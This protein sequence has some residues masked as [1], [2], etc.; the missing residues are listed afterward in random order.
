MF[1]VHTTDMK[2]LELWTRACVIVWYHGF[3]LFEIIIFEITWYF[4][5]V[6]LILLFIPIYP[7]AV[8][9]FPTTDMKNEDIRNTYVHVQYICDNTTITIFKKN[10]FFLMNMFLILI[11]TEWFP[12]WYHG[13]FHFEISKKNSWN[14]INNFIL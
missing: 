3:F 13:F 8:E 10:L 12:K 1:I 14:V 11:L 9:G 2:I 5:W 4:L 6:T 7:C